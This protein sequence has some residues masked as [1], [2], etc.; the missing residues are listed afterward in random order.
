MWKFQGQ[1]SNLVVRSYNQSH[2]NDNAGS[3]THWATK[4]LQE[5]DSQGEK[6]EQINTSGENVCVG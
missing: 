5:E 4:E 1:G 3:L 6:K 2:S